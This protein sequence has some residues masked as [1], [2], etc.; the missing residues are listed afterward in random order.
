MFSVMFHVKHKLLFF[1]NFIE[2]PL[3]INNKRLLHCNCRPKIG[4]ISNAATGLRHHKGCH[5][6][7]SGC[8]KNYCECFEAK[9]P[10]TDMCKCVDCKNSDEHTAAIRTPIGGAPVSAIKRA[11][12]EGGEIRS[13]PI[14]DEDEPPP[15]Q[16]Y[17]FMTAE[18]VDATVQCMMAQADECQQNGVSFRN[19]ERLILEEFGRCL[20]EIIEFSQNQES[21]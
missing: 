12:A 6:K 1:V 19:A 5:C 10:C 13:K 9:I 11:A 8:L 15:K 7:R 3:I 17:N 18:V 20:G 14:E 16:P 2:N 21:E 4:K